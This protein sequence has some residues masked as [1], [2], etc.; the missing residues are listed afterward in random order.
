MILKKVI[1]ENFNVC[2][3]C[4]IHFIS[5]KYPYIGFGKVGRSNSQEKIIR[6]F[7]NTPLNLSVK[8]HVID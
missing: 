6:S 1:Y 4:K 5:E 8:Y 2:F 3:A 7:Q